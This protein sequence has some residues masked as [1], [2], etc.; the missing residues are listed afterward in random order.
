MDWKS[1]SP[2]CFQRWLNKMVTVVQMERIHFLKSKTTNRVMKIW[3][4]F[5]KS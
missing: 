5:I 1:P 4:P 3:G 2:P